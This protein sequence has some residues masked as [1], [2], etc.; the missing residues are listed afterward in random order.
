MKRI[1]A[2][3]TAVSILMM[4]TCAAFA[5]VIEPEPDPVEEGGTLVPVALIVGAV[6]V[7]VLV[8]AV[9]KKKK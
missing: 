1:G 6:V 4:Q 7:L 9:I 2:M 3:L 5:D 8:I